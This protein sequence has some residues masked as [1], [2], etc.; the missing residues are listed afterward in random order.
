LKDLDLATI[1]FISVVL[2]IWN[3]D[4]IR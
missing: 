4:Q 2:G 3:I 1:K